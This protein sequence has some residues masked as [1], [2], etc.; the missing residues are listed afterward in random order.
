MHNEGK[1]DDRGAARGCW[2]E[3]KD[4]AAYV[5]APDLDECANGKDCGVRDGEVL[6]YGVL[7][8]CTVCRIHHGAGVVLAISGLATLVLMPAPV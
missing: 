4:N 5:A 1:Q 7:G 8:R 3:E 2:T 6:I